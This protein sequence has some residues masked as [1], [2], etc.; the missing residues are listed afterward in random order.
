MAKVTYRAPA[1]D[2]EVVT[3]MGVRF[4]DGIPLD[5]AAAVVAKA[6][7]NPHFVVEAADAEP[8]TEKRGPGRPRKQD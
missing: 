5:V 2:A 8:V 1:G 6:A 3:F 7:A 4:F